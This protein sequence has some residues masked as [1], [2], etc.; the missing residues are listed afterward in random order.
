MQRVRVQLE[1]LEQRVGASRFLRRSVPPPPAPSRAITAIAIADG[2][3]RMA[4]FAS[5]RCMR[6]SKSSN[7][8]GF[9]HHFLRPTSVGSR[10]AQGPSR[11]AVAQRWPHAPSL[12]G[13]ALLVPSARCG[14]NDASEG[15]RYRARGT[16]AA[17]LYP[18]DP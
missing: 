3:M 14:R 7:S 17:T 15:A 11:P 9:L 8:H 5:S 16:R 10:R 4:C 13:R 12:P 18:V 6:P 2:L 1:K